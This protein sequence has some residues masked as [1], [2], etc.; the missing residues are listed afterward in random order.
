MAAIAATM[1][2]LGT[3]GWFWYASLVPSTYSVMGMGYT[4]LG[5]GP[6]GSHAGHGQH[7][8]YGWD[9]PPAQ[10]GD[11]SV[12]ELTGPQEG[13]P[14]VAVTVTARKGRF[15][16]ATGE[17]VDGY[18]LNG[19]SPGPEI[20]ARQGDLVEVTLVNKSV[21]GGATLHWHGIDVPNAEDGV[22]GVTQDAVP[23]GGKHVYRYVAEDAG[24]YWYHSHQVSHEQVKRGLFGVVVI[25]PS[26][27]SAGATDVVAA[28]HSYSGRRTISGRTG[29]QT[30]ETPPGETTRVRLV[31]T[32]NGPLR[33]WVSNSPFR[34]L[35]VDGRD[36]NEPPE[37]R[38]HLLVVTAGGRID[39]ELT[40]PVDGGAARLDVG[41]G[42]ALLIAPEEAPAA[43]PP[44][45]P[46]ERL[47]LLGYGTP[48]DIA[49][50]PAQADRRFDFH[51][52]RRPGFVDG[53][54]GFWWTINGKLFPDVPMFM[55]AEG[56]IVRMTISNSSGDVHPMHLHGHHAVVLSRNGVAA[57]GSPWWVD[58][59]NVED[60]ETYE[61]A[62]VA[63]NLGIW[64]DHCHNL[65]HAADGLVA[66]LAYA[67]VSEPYRVGKKVG[68]GAANEPE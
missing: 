22:A 55:V 32:D 14:D 47:D 24:T 37:V 66:H 52:G 33:A 20:R 30:V 12:A 64:M 21:P 2:I 56:D 57:T 51:V 65:D 31:N 26:G 63:D 60:D 46:T 6:A 48:S 34:V 13:T 38:D 1:A 28:V 68:G 7:G 27:G 25:E 18:T 3:L 40:S 41:G 49:F 9:G 45:P 23:V 4:D 8:D 62:F 35:A 58:S 67:G 50:D 17:E 5:G 42:T 54:P 29:T 59:L 15:E 39:L 16:L 43:A 53:Y 44:P 10:P 61:V 36:V 11:V 19:T